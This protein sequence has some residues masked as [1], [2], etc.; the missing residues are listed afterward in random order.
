MLH[1]PAQM[2]ALGPLMRHCCI[3]FEARH[4][5]FKN[6]CLTLAEKCQ[7]DASADFDT[8]N[9]C[10]HSLFSTDKELGPTRPVIN[11]SRAAILRKIEDAKLFVK[12]E[13]I[14]KVFTSKWIKLYGTK[15]VTNNNCIIAIDATFVDKV[16]N[17]GKQIWLVD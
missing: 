10:E 6:I 14:S 2:A 16:P 11:E 17:F 1:I 7:L 12:P 15:Y 3:R 13:M 8:E 5:Y 9:P 4:R